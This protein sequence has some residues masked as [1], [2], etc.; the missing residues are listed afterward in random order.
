MGGRG[1]KEQAR[2]PRY[3][4]LNER[5]HWQVRREYARARLMVISSNQRRRGER[6]VGGGGRR[7]AGDCLGH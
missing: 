2:N 1:R 5:P 4:W 7:S 6:G 3:R